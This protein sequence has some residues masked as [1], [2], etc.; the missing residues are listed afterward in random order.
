MVERVVVGA[1]QVYVEVEGLYELVAE[2]GIQAKGHSLCYFGY[3]HQA[4][5]K[6]S[7]YVPVLFLVVVFFHFGADG[8]VERDHL[9]GQVVEKDE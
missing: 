2:M 5:V 8:L 4:T 7:Y 9:V 1:Q 6:Q 3:Y